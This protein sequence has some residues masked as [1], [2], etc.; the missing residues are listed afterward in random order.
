MTL[1]MRKL[2]IN[3]VPL[4]IGVMAFF[5]I[6]GPRA[7]APTNI[8]WLGSG[9]PAAHYL[10]WLFFRH[11][12]WTFPI[13]MNPAYGL[14]LSSAI[15]FSDSNPLLAFVFKLLDPLLSE[16]F[17]YFGI[18]LLACFVLQ[19]WFGWKLAG[20]ISD[21]KAIQGL[22]AALFVFAPP[23]VW[24]LHGHLNL[25]GHFLILAALYLGFAREVKKRQVAWALLLVVSALVHGYLMAMVAL[26]WIADLAQRAVRR[27]LLPRQFMLELGIVTTLTGIACW[28]AGYFSVGAGTSAGGY[29]QYRLNLL[30]LVNPLGWSYVIKDLPQGGGD[31]EGFNFLGLGIICLAVC[32]LPA[33]LAGNTHLRVA[34]RKYPVLIAAFACLAAFAISNNVGLGLFQHEFPLP[35][36]ILAAAS[37]FRA[38]GRMFWPV[39]YAIVL[40]VIF[41]VVRGYSKRTAVSLLA[42]AVVVQVADTSAEW[43]RIRTGLMSE[44]G[45]ELSTPLASPFWKNAAARYST[46]R[47]IPPGT[48]FPQWSK[49]AAFAAQNALGTDAVYLARFSRRALKQAQQIAS[50]NVLTGRYDSRTLYV[51]DDSTL[52]QAALSI[53]SASDALL[54]VDGFNL[55]APGWKKCRDCRRVAQELGSADLLRQLKVGER[56]PTNQAGAGLPYLLA[57]WSSA[58]EWGTWSD[59]E[60]AELVLPV[61][62]MV[63]SITVEARALVTPAYPKQAVA[64]RINGEL[65]LTTSLASADGALLHIPVPADIQEK[66]AAV[67]FMRVKF[68]F[69]NAVQPQHLG[70][71]DDLRKLAL[72]LQA[73][74]LH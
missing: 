46:V 72:G 74:T 37:F 4:M 51:L 71:N 27:S 62:G 57:G 13:G 47:Y 35:R 58:E 18:W 63:K 25:V 70:L 36:P 40:A 19:A 11:S 34:L 3:A 32:A 49:I 16:P 45:S 44:P 33:A 29:G 68:E 6:V 5:V 53:D 26:L 59:G 15:I 1:Q 50:E 61:A 43:A 22:S 64:V 23:F 21:S 30:S 66:S 28:Q 42:F 17:Q 14:E 24:R 38:S 54:K 41:L 60:S 20:R 69:P 65:V 12:A 52:R 39:F 9:D 2:V 67:G 8:A 56:V 31:Y 73:I 10:G 48:V 7:L 55:L